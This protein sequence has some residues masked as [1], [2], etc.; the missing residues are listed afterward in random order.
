MAGSESGRL[1]PEVPTPKY[2]R[3]FQAIVGIA[4]DK[5]KTFQPEDIEALM[6]A[7]YMLVD[8]HPLTADRPLADVL[9]EFCKDMAA[10]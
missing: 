8:V 6:A 3:Y 4:P 1:I 5:M 2:P 10:P 9:R 7:F